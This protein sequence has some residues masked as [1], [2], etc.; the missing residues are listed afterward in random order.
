M[1]A[2]RFR[3]MVDLAPTSTRLIEALERYLKA[4]TIQ[5]KTARFP[6]FVRYYVHENDLC[7][8]KSVIPALKDIADTGQEVRW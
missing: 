4:H 2:P 3:K 7:C 8:A 5:F 6:E 1:N